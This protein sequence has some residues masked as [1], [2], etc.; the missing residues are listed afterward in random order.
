MAFEGENE[1]EKKAKAK[2][3][4]MMK[5]AK[6]LH[7]LMANSG[8][9][10]ETERLRTFCCKTETMMAKI[11][12]SLKLLPNKTSFFF[13]QHF[14]LLLLSLLYL[15]QLFLFWCFCCCDDNNNTTFEFCVE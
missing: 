12:E 9:F 15:L 8:F 4:I 6:T 7:G 2:W 14:L 5:K 1:A 11:Q 13:S 3:V 10:L